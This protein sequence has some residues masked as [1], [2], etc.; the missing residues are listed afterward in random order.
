MMATRG[1]RKRKPVIK[2]VTNG[3]Y[4]VTGLEHLGSSEGQELPVQPVIALCRCGASRNKPY[5][6]GS[7]TKIGFVGEKDPNRVAGEVN[8]WKG[9]RITI[10]DN[11]GVCCRDRSCI[12]NLPQ[13]FAEENPDAASIKEIIDTIRKCPSGALSYKV[14]GR[15]C[16]SFKR[17]PAITVAKD[18][19]LK[20]VGGIRLKDEMDS[21]PACAEHYTLCRCGHSKNKPFC[22]GSHLDIGFKDDMSSVF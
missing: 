14:G 7:H 4:I 9:K 17:E 13:V 15:H 16:Q 1:S 21:E 3:P 19:P 6:D 5:C 20:V 11:T 10:V 8:E 12:N 18:G 2:V 22:D